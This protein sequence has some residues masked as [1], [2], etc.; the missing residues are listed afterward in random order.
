MFQR[1]LLTAVL[2]LVSTSAF[3]APTTYTIDGNHTQTIFNWNHFGFSNPT[4]NFDKIEGTITYDPADVS[5]SSVEVT[6]AIDSIN[7]HVPKFDT[8]MKSAD[9]F[10]AAQFPTATFKSTRVEKGPTEG[11]LKVTGDLTIHGVTRSV[12][13]DAR[14]NRVGEHPMKKVPM[15]GFDAGTTIKRSDFGMDF[16]VPNVSDEIHIRITTEAAV[17]KAEA[18]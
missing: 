13:L 5:K 7:T 8:H 2:A 14:L 6:I 17:P 15:I 16:L 3:A 18:K 4:A 1:T 11:A 12:V 9:L 10:D